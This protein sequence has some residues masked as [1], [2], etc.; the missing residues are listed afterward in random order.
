MWPYIFEVCRNDEIIDSDI[1]DI[2]NQ[3]NTSHEEKLF[4]HISTI[5]SSDPVKMS[6]SIFSARCKLI[7]NYG[8]WGINLSRRRSW[9][10]LPV[11][12]SDSQIY[13]NCRVSRAEHQIANGTHDAHD[14]VKRVRSYRHYLFHAIFRMMWAAKIPLRNRRWPIKTFS[15]KLMHCAVSVRDYLDLHF[16]Q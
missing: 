16:V 13:E 1:N 8:S 14:K 7:N 12:I 11:V 9:L 2:Y 10:C 15:P 5:T 6:R 4:A 3:I